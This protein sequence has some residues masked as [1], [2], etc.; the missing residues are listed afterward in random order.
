[1]EVVIKRVEKPRLDL[2]EIW[3]HREL[4]YLL[5]WRDFKVRYKQTVIGA[6]WVV[7]QPVLTMVVFTVFFNRLLGVTSPGGN[8]AT[9]AFVGLIYWNLFATAFQYSSLSI[10]SNQSLITK[11]YFPRIIAPL[12]STLVFVVDFAVASLVLIGLMAFYGVRPGLLGIALVLPLLIVTLL[13]TNGLGAFFAAVNVKYRDVRIAVPYLTQTL[14]FVTPVIYPV[15]YIPKSF[16][17][18]TY[19]NPM[20][21]VVTAIR[22]ELIH[23]GSVS[24]PGVAISSAVAVAAA[25]FGVRYFIRTERGFADIA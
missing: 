8:Y 14:L 11:V 2:G 23:Q 18:F 1:M 17:V 24:W 21:G 15:S 6:S 25:L 16:R 20:A 5:A 12:A 13:W 7:F 19:I 4:L 22:A 3:A 9:F 10:I